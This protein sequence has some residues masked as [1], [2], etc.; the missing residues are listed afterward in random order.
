MIS[1][2]Y[3]EQLIWEK[4]TATRDS[5]AGDYLIQRYMPLVSYHVQRISIGLPKSV[6]KDE[7]MSLGMYGLYDA[8]KKFDPGRD[9]KFDTYASFRIRGTI[10]DGLRKED[11]LPRSSRE[12]AKKIDAA[13]EKLEQKHL[14][15]VTPREIAA[16]LRMSEEDVVCIVNEGFFANVL[17]IDD[18]LLDHDESDHPGMMI[19]DEKAVTPEDK[20]LKDEL[21]M[22]LSEVIE[23]LS[24]KEQLVIS[25]FYKEELT[26]TE[27]GQVME[28]ST[29]RISQIHSKALFKLRRIL[30]KA[31]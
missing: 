30:E 18:Q 2:A 16:E 19:K 25:L 5:E 20:L 26:L 23:E 12:K 13:I 7:L 3:E 6:I 8:L 1:A 11:W 10:I 31:V 21:L 17:S 14:R 29:S 28:L 9:L 4:W 15:N 24:E 27:I 22:Q